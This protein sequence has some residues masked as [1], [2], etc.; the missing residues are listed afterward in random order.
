MPKLTGKIFLLLGLLFILLAI[1]LPAMQWIPIGMAVAI[2]VPG[3]VLLVLGWSFGRDQTTLQ[4][5]PEILQTLYSPDRKFR[6]TIQRRKDGQ[7]QIDYWALVYNQTEH[8]L[9]SQYTRQGGTTIVSSFANAEDLAAERL[10]AG[11]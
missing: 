8:G 3:I 1:F 9:E 10:R 7:I 5:A 2:A 6:A 11:R 4:P